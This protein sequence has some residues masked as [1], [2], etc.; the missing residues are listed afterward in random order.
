MLGSSDSD[1][2]KEI[3]RRKPRSASRRSSKQKQKIVSSDSD[4]S[5]EVL[6]ATPENQGESSRSFLCVVKLQHFT[7]RLQIFGFDWLLSCFQRRV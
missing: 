4:Q 7:G 3:Q 1:F 6:K 2:E 5:V